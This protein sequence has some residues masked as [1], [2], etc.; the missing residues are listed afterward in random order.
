M[1][2]IKLD[3][4]VTVWQDCEDGQHYAAAELV[5]PGITLRSA[6]SYAANMTVPGNYLTQ[7]AGNH[8]AAG[9]AYLQSCAVE[10][11]RYAKEFIDEKGVDAYRA[12]VAAQGAGHAR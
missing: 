7:H 5:L 1:D 9:L 4:G 8:R 12:A 6:Y 3:D 2:K 10:E 11:V